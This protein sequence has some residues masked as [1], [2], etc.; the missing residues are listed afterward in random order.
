MGLLDR[1]SRLVRAN[2]NAFV[3][4]AEDPIKILDQSVA[5]M[6]EDLVKLRQAVAIAIA[7]QKRLENQ[8]NQAREQ[9]QNWLSRAELALKKGEDDLAREA[10]SRKKTFQETFES[11][12]TQ[13]QSQNGQVEKLK[14]SLLLLERKIAEARTKKDMLKAR[15][16]AAKAQQKIQSAVG[17]LGGKSAMAAFERMEDKVEALEASGQAALELA[18]EDLESKFAALEGGDDIEKELETLRSQLKS[19]VEAIALPPSDL[20]VNEV[21]T[22]EIQEVEVE[23]EE[24]KKSMDNS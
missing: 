7:S 6:Q 15:A 21:K 16:Q 19:G 5:D 1:L 22:V 20:D 3:S 9:I 18:G 8:A 24:M 13:F 12:T 4:D 11:L 2:L 10:L 14:K 17:D 23:L